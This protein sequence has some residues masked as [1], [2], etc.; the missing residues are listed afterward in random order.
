MA[1]KVCLAT[2]RAFWYR[3]NGSTMRVYGLL[4]FLYKNGFELYLFYLGKLT[5]EDRQLL[6]KLN[7]KF[8]SLEE[9][10]EGKYG[11]SG[12]GWVR[13]INDFYDKDVL[14]SFDNFVKKNKPDSIIY[15]YIRLWYLLDIFKGE[16]K[17]FTKIKSFIDTHD[18]MHLRQ[19]QFESE[20]KKHWI[21]ISKDE[22]INVLAKFD[23]IMAI[24]NKEKAIFS[25]MFTE[26]GIKSEVIEVAH[27]LE[28]NQKLEKP[29]DKNIIKIVYLACDNEPNEDALKYFLD[30]VMPIYNA[31]LADKN[32][33]KEVIFLVG[34]DVGRHIKDIKYQYDK[35][36]IEQ[37]NFV[38]DLESF[39]QDADIVINPI[40]YGGGLKIKC[41]EAL[42]YSL[43]L[44]TTRHGSE[45]LEKEFS[46]NIITHN[47]NKPFLVA[48][49]TYDFAHC[50]LKL[51][52]SNDTR[53]K[54]S[55]NAYQFALKNFSEDVVYN[56][57]K[58]LL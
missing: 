34:G 47:F 23:Y 2:D 15:E 51:T 24:Q 58:Q 9:A 29:G 25:K 21:N 52:L 43:P 49:N 48:N 5:Q 55:G 31:K 20:G 27:A 38:S 1:K 26:K 42:C 16:S 45:G 44:I 37:I 14:N 33:D 56:N 36:K 53:N 18:I 54:I 19:K 30:E 4:D 11:F 17:E 50:L 10:G 28:V 12:A 8:K 40:Q 46:N 6:D 39:Y 22:E 7:I 3:N 41:V 35:I 57:L 13:K 32:F